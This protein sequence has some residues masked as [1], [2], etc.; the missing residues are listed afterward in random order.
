[1]S[2]ILSHEAQSDSLEQ[3]YPVLPIDHV[4]IH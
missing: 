3:G 2:F 1:M 4:G